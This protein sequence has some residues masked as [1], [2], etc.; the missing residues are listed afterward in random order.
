MIGSRCT[1]ATIPAVNISDVVF[2]NRR[3]DAAVSEIGSPSSVNVPRKPLSS[4]KLGFKGSLA[5]YLVI[6]T[7]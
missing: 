2:V 6:F 5:L 3:C 1:Y 4:R 7:D